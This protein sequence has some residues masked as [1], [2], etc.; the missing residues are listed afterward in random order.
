MTFPRHT[1]FFCHREHLLLSG[2]KIKR[3]LGALNAEG[4]VVF[5][6]AVRVQGSHALWCPRARPGQSDVPPSQNEAKKKWNDFKALVCSSS[7]AVSGNTDS[8]VCVDKMH[9]WRRRR[10]WRLPASC[11]QSPAVRQVATLSS[12]LLLTLLVARSFTAASLPSSA[13]YPPNLAC[14]WISEVKAVH[15]PSVVSLL[16]VR[17][18][19]P[20]GVLSAYF[21]LQRT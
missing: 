7:K 14:R 17:I 20:A 13:P 12:H 2:L 15:M 1:L 3:A 6:A 19:A 9:T 16:A 4:G 5:C 10:H 8:C 11:P 18:K 21:N